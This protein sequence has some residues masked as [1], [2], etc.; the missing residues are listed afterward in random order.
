MR[1]FYLL[2]LTQVLATSCTMDIE[3]YTQRE[4]EIPE[5][6][7]DRIESLNLIQN[8]D[9]IIMINYHY[10][11]LLPTFET[12]DEGFIMLSKNRLTRFYKTADDSVHIQKI[13][14]ENCLNISIDRF[15]DV[16]GEIHYTI[17]GDKIGFRSFSEKTNRY[18]L[19]LDTDYVYCLAESEYIEEQETMIDLML[20]NWTRQ[21]K[22]DSLRNIYLSHYQENG[23]RI[24][25]ED[26]KVSR[27]KLSSFKRDIETIAD[28]IIDKIDW[29]T[30]IANG[31]ILHVNYDFFEQ[32]YSILEIEVED[33]PTDD[34]DISFIV[35][36]YIGETRGL[37]E[38]LQLPYEY[39]TDW[40][41]FTYLDVEQNTEKTSED[42][43]EKYFQ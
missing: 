26:I 22:H 16:P 37:R 3:N 8:D 7:S 1:N 27:K 24:V 4:E 43:I 10:K 21:I 38:E 39:K 17:R 19:M 15:K 33:L 11:Q 14:L 34:S 41:N 20:K 30:I 2:L 6:I 9:S 32:R 25:T 23:E 36:H 13:D 42:I 40:I 28:K 18:E 35:F 29:L 5:I 12:F 31:K